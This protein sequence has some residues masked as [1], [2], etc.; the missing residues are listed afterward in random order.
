MNNFDLSK[1]K[2][3]SVKESPLYPKNPILIVDDEVTTSQL[4]RLKLEQLGYS[5]VKIC[6][7]SRN[8][9]P[10][11]NH[12]EFE[13]VLLDI[14]MPNITGLELY[15]KIINDFQGLPVIM[16]TSIDDIDTAIQCINGGVFDYLKKSVS[17]TRLY[18]S[19][20]RA[21]EYRDM[22]RELSTLKSHVLK[23]ELH[24]P[25]AF[26]QIISQNDT[27]FSVFQYVE[28]IAPTM[29]PVFITGET[30]VGKGLLAEALHIISARKGPFIQVNVSGI[31]S[32]LFADTLFGHVKGAY[33]GANSDRIGLCEKASDGTLFLDEIGD[34]ELPLQT[35]LLNLL[36]E[37]KYYPIGEDQPRHCNARIITATNCDVTEL[38]DK[39][40]F[41]KDLY[42]RL[43][44]HHIQIPPLRE[45]M[46]DLPVLVDYFLKQGA[47]ELNKKKPAVYKEMIQVL[48]TYTYPGNIREL[49][50]MVDDALCQ[51]TAHSL[52][53]KTF[54][55]YIRKQSQDKIDDVENKYSIQ[56]IF[57]ILTSL[58]TI[59]EA[60]EMLVNEALKRAKGNLSIAAPILGI[61]RQAL[62][63]RIKRRKNLECQ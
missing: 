37:R 41:R 38:I 25:N 5:N 16:L 21:I 33:T 62:G 60:S 58:P 36:Q 46:D 4:I 63:K 19:I 8:V 10:M 51:H 49:K 7:D 29:Y 24:H 18:T 40:A 47:K 35:K 61:S 50:A 52:S 31:D 39:K 55:E 1:L 11:L 26:S 12:T 44:T 45:R 56:N 32:S 34:L 59:K 27:M 15:P 28:S 30:G 2:S 23:K 53:L 42:F 43:H 48:N 9:M 14:R 17:D 54:K 20:H 13:L 57:K 6:N 22:N 3:I